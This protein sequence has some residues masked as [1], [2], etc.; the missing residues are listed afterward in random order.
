MP[1][2]ATSC[3]V[4]IVGAGPYG[5]SIAAYL[6]AR[7]LRFRIFGNPMESW[8]LRMPAGMFLKSEG[9]ASNLYDPEGQFTLERYCSENNLPYADVGVPIPL[10]T[11]CDYGL[12]FQRRVVP[13]VEN[14]MVAAV[15]CSAR[16][17]QLRLEDG[18]VLTAGRVVV[19]AGMGLFRYVPPVLTQLPA[20]LLSHSFEHHDLSRFRDVDVT[21][22]G[23]GASALDLAVL[24]REIGAQVR[25]VVR[26]TFVPFLSQPGPRSFR[27]RV[28]YPMSGIGC[29]WRHLFFAK[30]PMFFRHLSAE[31]RSQIVENF[32]GPAGAWFIR[33]RIA[34]RVP[35]LLGAAPSGAEVKDGRVRLQFDGAGTQ[36]ELVT[37][38]V[39]AATGYRVDI[40]RLAFL[41]EEIR[42]SLRPIG[43]A[44]EL[45][46]N[47]ES[48]VPGLYFAGLASAYS[49][50]PVMR[51][52]FG[53]DFTARRLSDHFGHVAREHRPVS[54]AS[55]GDERKPLP[56]LRHASHPN[57]RGAAR[58]KTPT[59]APTTP[60][61]VLGA[62]ADGHGIARSL[63]RAGI[64]VIL[65]D[66]DPRRAGL[67]TRYARP[68]LVP[69]LSGPQL[70]DG[71]LALGANL[72]AQAVLFPTT[73]RQVRVISDY[74]E[75]LA[76]KFRICLPE[77]ELLRELLHKRGFQRVA[78][79][80]GFPAPR[81]VTV[82]NERDIE[83]L[84]AI[85]YPAVIKPGDKE[86]FF[87][88]LVWRARRVESRE[89]AE[90]CCRAVLAVAPDLIVQEWVEGKESDIYFC[91]QYR[92]EN[93]VTVS[94]FTGRKL[95]C[96]PPQTGST[97]SC[98]AAPQV[99]LELESLTKAFFDYTNVVGMC[100][101]EF[102]REPR[103]GNFLMIEPTIGR[104][105]WQEEVA[106]LNGENIPLA[107]Y[108]DLLGLRI[109]P[110]GATPQ[111]RVWVYPPSYWRSVLAT[112]S[113]EGR[114]TAAE[115][116]RVT[117]GFGDPGPLPFYLIEWGTKACGVHRW[118]ELVSRREEPASQLR[119]IFVQG[120]SQLGSGK[121]R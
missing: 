117:G 86:L 63:G 101:M 110:A 14:R 87:R 16:G 42:N 116:W 83:N 26:K 88:G 36:S 9:F 58:L 48:S 120:E 53:A 1:E 98:T 95:R 68:F 39:I 37:E 66:A 23:G 104:T 81:A 59:G 103:K 31:K 47:F 34:G 106:S 73:D 60:A 109:P 72:G 80:G 11:L 22:V 17:F 85:R 96:W 107:A 35:F 100:S 15:E 50:G 18:E 89:E 12:A 121:A 93:G 77:R 62:D 8:R 7:G 46:A 45:S 118:R 27:Y 65:V 51:F 44:P 19:A 82:C 5:L 67:R 41:S 6:R 108:H 38:H 64:P 84:A 94:S 97:A 71:L 115:L 119:P 30:A 69:A 92:N 54:V 13:E 56:S 75:Q 21:V 4:A 55:C 111:P 61:V 10:Q 90:A 78:E 105:D 40:H 2:A 3:Q 70:I 43:T 114:P 24:L 57:A 112:R 28:R 25:V 29:G 91:L 102:K 32:L 99:K 113:L 33:D 20:E 76:G 49:F 79:A 52:M 74:R